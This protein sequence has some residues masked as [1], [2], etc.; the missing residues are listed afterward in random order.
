MYI[1]VCT[2]NLYIILWEEDD[3]KQLSLVLKVSYQRKQ[4]SL[5]Q[6]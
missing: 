4:Q 1:C 2:N 3:A 6:L 5:S